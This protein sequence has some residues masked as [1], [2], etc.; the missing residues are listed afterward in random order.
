M[1]DLLIRGA[2]VVDGTG[3]PAFVGDVG[4]RDG[5]IVAVGTIDEP[6]DRTVDADGLVLAPGVIDIHTHYD[7]QALWDPA[8]TPSPLHGVTTVIGGNCGF[9][10]APLVPDAVDYVMQ[11]MARV[12]GMPLDVARGRSRVGLAVVRRVARP[13]S[14][15]RLA[16]NAG[17]HVGHSTM[18]RVVMGDDA[19]H[20]AATPE[21]IAAMVAL[22]HES[23]RPARSGSRRR[24]ARRTATATAR[25]C[26]RAPRNPTSSS[27]SPR[28]CATTPA[29]ASSSSRPSGE[30]S[31][32]RIALMTDM[33]LAADR[34]L[35]WNLLGSASPTPSVRAAAHVLRP[36][37]RAR[38]A[39]RRARAARRHAPAQQPDAPGDA[40]MGRGDRAA[41]RRAARRR[42]RSRGARPTARP[43]STPRP[44]R[45]GRRDDAVGPGRAR[46]TAAASRRVA[47]ERGTDAVDVLLDV[48]VP[49][50][51]RSRP[52][53][54]RW[55]RR[56]ASP[57]R[58]GRC[59]ARCGATSASC[60]AAP[61]PAR[62]STSCATPTT[63][64][65]CS[66]SW[67]DARPLHPGGGRPPDDRRARRA[68]RPARPRRHRR[69]LRTP[70]WCCSIPRPSPASRPRNATTCPVARCGC[71]PARSGIEQV[72]VDGETIVERG[73]LTG[74]QPG[75]L[76]RSGVDTDTVTVPAT[77][78]GEHV[79]DSEES[80]SSPARAA[81]SA[82]PIAVHL[83]RGRLRR[84][85]RGT[86]DARRRDSRALVDAQALRHVAPAGIGRRD[87][88]VGRAPRAA[89]PCACSSTSP[90]ARRSHRGRCRCSSG[91]AASTC[92][93][94]TAATSVPGTWTICSTRRWSC[95]TRTSRRT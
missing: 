19:T 84:R 23:L 54:R 51:C 87:R 28:A 70:T 38:R 30:I 53:S 57:T 80:R 91:G 40:R 45:R 94:T 52:C 9:S 39:R 60:S 58:A 24:S 21:Q 50:R 71:T 36:R 33:S 64:R 7:V 31:D 8:L 76:L 43:G 66:A 47:A 68:V 41:R 13:R 20:A 3:A 59:G 44:R 86:D 62:T 1:L 32:E 74:A 67:S 85:R 17:F 46:P 63:R 81:G 72:I 26:R 89:A 88:G 69:G 55:S 37:R 48:V 82:R 49:E 35:N 56:W 92:S 61:M 29:P 65:S 42:R 83:A 78:E 4:V 18:R 79:S 10:I 27:P 22:L 90:T 5:R 11:M 75:T 95:S 12:E 93:S 14:T 2:R 6:A 15:A 77:T 25:R 73:G 16:V 34:P